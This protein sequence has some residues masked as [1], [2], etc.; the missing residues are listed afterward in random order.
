[1]AGSSH[2]HFTRDELLDLLEDTSKDEMDVGIDEPV[3]E[4]SDEDLQPEDTL[5]RC[6]CVYTPLLSSSPSGGTVSPISWNLGI[7]WITHY[8]DQ[9][10]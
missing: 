10:D 8:S 7:E 2:A 1:M 4:G 6:T 9:N 3:C 5:G